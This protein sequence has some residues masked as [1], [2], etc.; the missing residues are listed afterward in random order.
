MCAKISQQSFGLSDLPFPSAKTKE[1]LREH[2]TLPAVARFVSQFCPRC[3]ARMPATAANAPARRV[4]F[5]RQPP[6][7]AWCSM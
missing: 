1:A 3:H 6:L 7:P 4:V 5:A 2:A